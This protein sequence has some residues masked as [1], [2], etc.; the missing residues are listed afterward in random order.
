MIEKTFV[1]SLSA[2]L[3]SSVVTAA[4]CVCVCVHEYNISRRCAIST[5]S[6]P[7]QRPLRLQLQH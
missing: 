2:V 6:V 1:V 5:Q 7:Q 4:V 3:W